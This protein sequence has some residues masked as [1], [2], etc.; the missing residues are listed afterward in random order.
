[1]TRQRRGTITAALTLTLIVAAGIGAALAFA[2]QP[3]PPGG[4]G[5]ST[6]LNTTAPKAVAGSLGALPGSRA[7]ETRNLA[8]VTIA[9]SLSEGH[10]AKPLGVTTSTVAGTTS[11]GLARE[12]TTE[13]AP[14][15]PV[16]ALIERNGG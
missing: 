6:V 13:T 11:T 15:G 9:G 10:E 8:P 1:M 12:E 16:A 4:S 7:E 14:R 3:S 2:K 5:T